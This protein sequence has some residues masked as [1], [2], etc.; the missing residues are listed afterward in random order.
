MRTISLLAALL[1]I[2]AALAL[3]AQTQAQTQT[4]G[5]T[6]K[7]DRFYFGLGLYR[8]N[9]DTQI[10]VDDAQTGASGTLLNLERDLDLSDRKTQTTFDAHFRF[11]KRHALE[12]EHVKRS[13]VDET[14][15][16]F[17]I[18]YDGEIIGINEDVQSTFSTEVSRLAYR[19]SFI[20]SERM[21]LSAALGLHV[22]DLKVGLNIVGE[23]EEFKKELVARE[24][25]DAL[26][27][28]RDFD[29]ALCLTCH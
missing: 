27:R 15:I 1:L 19:F 13:R 21:E 12:F 10:R 9:M 23:E 25:G 22:T 2:G 4:A 3:P 5:D 26:L 29:S 24:A 8:P 28:M 16:G 17:Q 6:W 20:N 14:N 11:A 7:K 18:D